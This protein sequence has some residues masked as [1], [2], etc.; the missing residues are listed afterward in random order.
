ME[1]SQS[2]S[3]LKLKPLQTS[4]GIVTLKKNKKFTNEDLP[5]T[6]LKEKKPILNRLS[7]M[8]Q[9][10][11][12]L[13]KEHDPKHNQFLQTFSS[14]FET[15]PT[16]IK[17]P[18]HIQLQ[19]LALLTHR[20]VLNETLDQRLNNVMRQHTPKDIRERL[21]QERKKDEK[22]NYCSVR[23]VLIQPQIEEVISLKNW[24]LTQAQLNKLKK[25]KEVNFQTSQQ[26][27]NRSLSELKQQY[28]LKEDKQEQLK[29]KAK[30]RQRNRQMS[31]DPNIIQDLTR[32]QRFID[33]L[34]NELE[35]FKVNLV[36]QE[37]SLQEN[38]LVKNASKKLESILRHKQEQNQ[39]S[40]SSIQEAP[41][42][43]QKQLQ[44]NEIKSR[45]DHREK[46]AQ[47]EVF[48]EYKKQKILK[49]LN[50][51][52]K[53]LN[54]IRKSNAIIQN[55]N[56]QMLPRLDALKNDINQINNK[57]H[58]YEILSPAYKQKSHNHHQNEKNQ[59]FATQLQDKISQLEEH[60]HLNN[61]NQLENNKRLEYIKIQQKDL[62]QIHDAVLD[63]QIKHY[64]ELL[65]EGIDSREYGL[66]WLIKSLWLLEQ[67]VSP[68][69]FPKSLDRQAI[70]YLFAC[71]KQDI[72]LDE[73]QRRIHT[74][75]KEKS[76]FFNNNE[77][78]IANTLLRE[79]EKSQLDNHTMNST[80]LGGQNFGGYATYRKLPIIET[81]KDLI[82]SLYTD[83]LRKIP[84]AN[85][86]ERI[87]EQTKEKLE[88]ACSTSRVIQRKEKDVTK[89]TV[90]T[91][92]HQLIED[93]MGSSPKA[94]R[95]LVV[96]LNGEVKQNQEHQELGAIGVLRLR[97]SEK[98]LNDAEEAYSKG[99]EN[100]KILRSQEIERIK[101]EFKS[102]KYAERFDTQFLIVSKALFGE[103]ERL[104]LV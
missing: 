92:F 60:L 86:K 100:L 14:P 44:L 33:Q 85:T 24:E 83:K 8:P 57:L 21:I 63:L 40:P 70:K 9:N 101:R 59:Q 55:E 99:K 104:K 81:K 56:Y 102:N 48:L 5:F 20:P 65:V 38:V 90:N 61:L 74:L 6:H 96:D 32:N 13:I 89:L 39:R 76:K 2:L 82:S 15:D 17:K 31:Q 66:Y 23:E 80:F 64:S 58:N 18:R 10:T 75:R 77:S 93:T 25:P 27:Q 71:A 68:L 12:C 49:D 46:L 4:G 50:N 51:L 37:V 3:T 29:K 16:L 78:I 7:L 94:K 72:E 95:S 84:L 52:T 41:N 43:T 36:L 22:L 73:L 34:Q 53:D 91:F 54:H 42:Q 30:G 1:K 35:H 19:S 67:E 97:I 69:Q 79:L 87:L 11:Q 103:L 98:R 28:S 26:H 47:K 62:K 88:E 45:T